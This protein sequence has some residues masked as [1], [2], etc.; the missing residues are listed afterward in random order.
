MLPLNEDLSVHVTVGPSFFS[1]HQDV[2]SDVTYTEVW[3]TIHLRKRR[4][5][6]YRTQRLAGGIQYRR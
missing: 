4:A 1:V 6:D 2:V 3:L 5:G